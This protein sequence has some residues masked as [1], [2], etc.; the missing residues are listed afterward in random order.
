MKKGKVKNFEDFEME[1]SK[2]ILL[3][4]YR[5]D[6]PEKFIFYILENDKGL[7]KDL[8]NL[9]FREPINSKYYY[10]FVDKQDIVAD[11]G[12]NL[13]Y[14]TLLSKKAKKILAIEPIKEILEILKKNTE[15]NHINNKVKILNYAISNKKGYILLKVENALNLSSV[16]LKKKNNGKNLRKVKAITLNDLMKVH[17]Y[18][19]IRMDVEG[20]EFEILYQKIPK[21]VN[22]IAI[23]LHTP[24]ISKNNMVKLFNY[25][26]REEFI[27]SHYIEEF[28]KRWWKYYLVCKKL[29]L[30]KIFTAV[31]EDISPK[32]CLKLI[33]NRVSLFGKLYKIIKGSKLCYILME[34]KK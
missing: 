26:D 32:E 6:I 20:H 7:S 19:F 29:K 21:E 24:I 12:A 17:F 15:I 13:G 10:Q 3:D 8:M 18:N 16:F 22:K 33:Y 5:I 11:I 2:K 28:P 23:E 4:L 1:Q 31:V 30:N 9:G 34:R 27:I 14:F 25:F